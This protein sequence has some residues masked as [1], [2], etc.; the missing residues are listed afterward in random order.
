MFY[1]KTRRDIETGEQVFVDY[2]DDYF[3][4]IMET[5]SYN[6]NNDN[7]NKTYLDNFQQF[8]KWNYNDYRKEKQINY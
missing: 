1:L 5:E 4:E 7:D 2:G 3:S 6:L 8:F